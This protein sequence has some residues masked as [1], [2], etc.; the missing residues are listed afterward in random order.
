MRFLKKIILFADPGIDDSIAIIY[1]LMHPEIE[2]LAIVSSYGNVTKQKAVD[3]AAFLL[4]EAGFPSLPMIGGTNSPLSGETPE[5]YPEIHGADGL[6]PLSPPP[7]KGH[8]NNFS[9]LYDILHAHSDITIVDIGRNTALAHLFLLGSDIEP[10]IKDIFLM[11][12]AFFVPGNVTPSAEA[13]FYGDPVAANI[14]L[15][16]FTPIYIIPLNVTSKAVITPHHI[17]EIEA[18]SSHPL[19]P[20]IKDLMKYYTEAYQ[21]LIPGIEG[22]PLHDVLTLYLMINPEAGRYVRRAVTVFMEGE[23]KGTSIADFRPGSRSRP[24]DPAICLEF[25]VQAF[26]E[27]FILT[28]SS[29]TGGRRK[30]EGR[31]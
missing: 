20:I 11:G 24:G 27:D 21:T 26:V 10:H 1:A 18:A 16:R 25:D 4:M 28:I 5:Y 9:D 7:Y 29:S 22:A 23:G 19:I 6:G 8:L 31:S 17:Q 14:V 12:G 30:R 15:S 13:N 2:V 3:N